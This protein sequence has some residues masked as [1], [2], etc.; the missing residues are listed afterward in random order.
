MALE[1]GA[2]LLSPI[3]QDVL[4][5]WVALVLMTLQETGVP[6]EPTAPAPPPRTT[7]EEAFHMSEGMR[8]FARHIIAQYCEQGLTF[9]KLQTT[10]SIANMEVDSPSV[11]VMQ[12]NTRLVVITLEVLRDNRVATAMSIEPR[13]AETAFGAV[14]DDPAQGSAPV[15]SA[16]SPSIEQGKDDTEPDDTEPALV[17][18]YKEAMSMDGVIS[19]MDYVYCFV[20]E[21][22]Q[23]SNSSHM[24]A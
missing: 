9:A 17:N 20:V 16:G 6:L 12:Q 8:G 18:G 1:T 14:Q 2:T 7:T 19:Q 22:K 24:V 4:L 21:S 13:E 5:A 15:D 23:V 10:Q 11:R 3:D